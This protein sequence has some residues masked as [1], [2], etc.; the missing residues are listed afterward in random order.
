MKKEVLISNVEN[1]QSS[2]PCLQRF[3]LAVIILWSVSYWEMNE[4][5]KV[6]SSYIHLVTFINNKPPPVPSS[7]LFSAP[8]LPPRIFDPF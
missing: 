2:Y 4:T 5:L 1:I 7:S 6:S 8:Y 3:L